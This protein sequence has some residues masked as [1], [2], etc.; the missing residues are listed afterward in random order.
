MSDIH[1]TDEPASTVG[2]P[3][4]RLE[5]LDALDDAFDAGALSK[6]DLVD[7]AIAANASPGVLELLRTLPEDERFRQRVDL[8]AHLPDVPVD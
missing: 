8:W 5:I 7:A 4:T 6:H 3:V 2:A 1:P